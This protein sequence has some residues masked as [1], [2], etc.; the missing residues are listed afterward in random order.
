V[1]VAAVLS[2]VVLASYGGYMAWKTITD[3]DR[4]GRLP[5]GNGFVASSERAVFA[6]RIAIGLGVNLR[7]LKDAYQFRDD[8]NRTIDT[9]RAERANLKRRS[10]RASGV[11]ADIVRSSIEATDRLEAGIAQWRD[12]IFSLRLGNAAPAESAIESAIAQL[13]A[14]VARWNS[15]RR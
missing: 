7:I 8:V 11:R 4:P 1:L 12:A 10:T 15:E 13:E 9:V 14:N 5:T 2:V 3:D 6:G